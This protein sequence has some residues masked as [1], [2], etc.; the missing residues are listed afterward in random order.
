MKV[1]VIEDDKFLRD[2]ALQ[3]I[4]KEGFNV[5]AAVDGEQGVEFAEKEIPDIILLDILLP[6]IDGFEVLSRVRANP[7]LAQTKVSMLSNFGQREDIEKALKGGADQFMVK[8]NYTLD[9][10]V[11]EVK[12]MVVTPH[13]Q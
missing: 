9:E 8:A 7:A 6:G 2:L 11:A 1:L 3:K 10:I 12:K 5:V 13:K 4:A